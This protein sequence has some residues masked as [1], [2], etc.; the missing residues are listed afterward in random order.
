M[1]KNKLRTHLSGIYNKDAKR[2]G[3]ANRRPL[4]K[5][6]LRSMFVSFLRE[7]EKTT[8]LELGAGAG[9][10]A[11]WFQ[12]HGFEVLATDISSGMVDACRKQGLEAHLLDVYKFSSLSSLW[13]GVYALNV[14]LHI[15]RR[16][17]PGIIKQIYNRLESG[18]VFFW[19][20][21][22]RG[23]NEEVWLEDK[24]QNLPLRFFSFLNDDTLKQLAEES[25]FRVIDFQK[26]GGSIVGRTPAEKKT[27][28]F[29]GLFLEKSSL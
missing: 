12:K 19:G 3:K 13:G 22:T 23:K 9:W 17:L 28:S 10:D 1:Q 29:Q 21:Y 24:T 20:C 5:R 7:R 27:F 26:L 4:W 8:I 18:G 11:A 16:D 25:G 15:P 14:L 2:R 6:H